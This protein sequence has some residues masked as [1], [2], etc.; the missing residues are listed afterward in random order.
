MDLTGRALISGGSAFGDR[1]R[2]LWPWLLVAIWVM[3]DQGVKRA[4][5]ANLPWQQSVELVPGVLNLVHVRNRG[6]A[7]GLLDYGSLW[8]WAILVGIMGGIVFALSVWLKRLEPGRAG[9]R[10]ALA[11]ILGGAVG[12]LLDRAR[13]GYVVDFIDLHWW[14]SYHYPAFNVADAGITLG[15]VI[16]VWLVVREEGAP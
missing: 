3:V 4:V 16:L 12:N 10:L 7:F 1:V 11:L 9:T 15:A 6:V 14:N 13:L 5:T 2:C 8:Q